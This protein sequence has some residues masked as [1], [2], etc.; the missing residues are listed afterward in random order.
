MVRGYC[1]GLCLKTP[2]SDRFVTFGPAFVTAGRF[3]KLTHCPTLDRIASQ[4]PATYNRLFRLWGRG[5]TVSV[6]LRC[7]NRQAGFPA[8]KREILEHHRESIH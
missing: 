1:A 2:F 5:P 3:P 6:R 7:Q 8:E 4:F